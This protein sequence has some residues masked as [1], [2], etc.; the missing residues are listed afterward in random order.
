V[1]VRK[2]FPLSLWLFLA[3]DALADGEAGRTE[4]VFLSL[5]GVLLRDVE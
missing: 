1:V 4:E 5:I 2:F 3:P